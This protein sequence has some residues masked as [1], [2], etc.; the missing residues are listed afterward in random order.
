[1]I[2]ESECMPGSK[3]C[4]VPLFHSVSLGPPPFRASF[5]ILQ[6]HWN[7][8]AFARLISVFANSALLSRHLT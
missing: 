7:C 8:Y 3:S 2:F 6:R 5:D 4:S 1:V